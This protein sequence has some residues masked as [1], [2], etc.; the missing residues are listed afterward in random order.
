M[1]VLVI[2]GANL[3]MLGRREPEIY[4]KETL[5][6]INS[7]LKDYA[8]NKGLKLDF[9]QSNLEGEIINRI[10]EAYG[11]YSYI[12]INPGAFTHTSIA[13]RDAILSVGI[14]FIEVHLSNVY[15][16]EPFRKFSYLSDVAK[17]VITGFGRDSYLMA[18]DY[19]SR[20]IK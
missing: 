10:H 5:D 3:N 15:A 12:I 6:D 16:R 1:N 11:K 18:I 2:N 7:Y 4:G 13:I 20:N 9:F 8:E 17:G 14:P 19:L